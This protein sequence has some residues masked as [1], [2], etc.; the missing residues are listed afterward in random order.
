MM[1][2]IFLFFH[3]ENFLVPFMRTLF[4]PRLWPR[5]HF[6]SRAL[7]KPKHQLLCLLHH[8]RTA[9]AWLHSIKSKEKL[10][11][12][13][14]PQTNRFSLF[15]LCCFS[16]RA[17]AQFGLKHSCAKSSVQTVRP[18]K[19]EL[20]QE[21]LQWHLKLNLVSDHN[22]LSQG[23]TAPCGTYTSTSHLHS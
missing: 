15:L 1:I 17:D 5:P 14:I 2:T 9:W 16:V 20:G 12:F 4:H 22:N 10:K 21:V 7:A 6:S 3:S 8:P 23:L 11:L 18:R 13:K 19:E